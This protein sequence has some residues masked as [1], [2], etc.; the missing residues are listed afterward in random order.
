MK[1]LLAIAAVATAI[2]PLSTAQAS[3]RISVHEINKFVA[4]FDAAINSPDIL[5]GRSFLNLNL[6][7]SASLENSVQ[8][9]WHPGYG[10]GYGRVALDD[11]RAYADYYRYPYAYPPHYRPSSL[12]VEGKTGIISNFQ[13]KK[14]IIPGFKQQTTVTSTTMPA[15]ATSAIV[16][17]DLK[18]F[19]LRYAGY[20]PGLTN[21]VLNTDSKC[22]MFLDKNSGDIRLKRM[23]C[24]SISYLPY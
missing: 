20:H 11:N 14:Q 12:Q 15:D 2:L 4:K 24:N 23:V 1:K 19:G 6:K 13:S 18:E 8:F 9:P 21:H 16:D 10:A 17:V 7:E 22:K 3:E 5:V